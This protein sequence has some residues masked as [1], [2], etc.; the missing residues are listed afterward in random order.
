MLRIYFVALEMCRD[1]ARVAKLIEKHDVNLAKQLRRCVSSVPLN[2]AE[3]G[4]SFG[5]NRKMRYH[6]ALGSSDEVMACYDTAEAMEYIDPVGTEV[7]GR[8]DHVIGTM[9][10]VLGL[11]RRC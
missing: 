1:A 10:N 3:G 8:V 5:G 11:R 9:V 6:T 4:G 2:I 7:R